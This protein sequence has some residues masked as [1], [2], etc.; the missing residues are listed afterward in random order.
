MGS[1]RKKSTKLD[2]VPGTLSVHFLWGDPIPVFV[3]SLRG[4]HTTTIQI[5]AKHACVV[6]LKPQVGGQGVR[7]KVIK[8]CIHMHTIISGQ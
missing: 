2:G 3:G 6:P 5:L 4:D 8:G 7:F 1:H